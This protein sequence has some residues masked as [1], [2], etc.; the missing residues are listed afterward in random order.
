MDIN[1]A[2]KTFLTKTLWV[3]LPFFAIYS[4]TKEFVMKISGEEK[5]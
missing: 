1:K 2:L 4:L 3:W 5:K